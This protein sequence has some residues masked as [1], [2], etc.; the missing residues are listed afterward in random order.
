MVSA[1]MLNTRVLITAIL[2][3]AVVVIALVVGLVFLAYHHGDASTVLSLVASIVSIINLAQVNALR[4]VISQL[5]DQT[6]GNT[7]K[8]IEAA[9]QSTPPVKE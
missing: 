4:S 1:L 6:N 7:T 3:G 2:S 8:L 9:I 5:R